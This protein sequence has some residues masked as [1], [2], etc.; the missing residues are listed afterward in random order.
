MTYITITLS[1]LIFALTSFFNDKIVSEK[2]LN[3]SKKRNERLN[4]VISSHFMNWTCILLYENV[5]N[6]IS[7]NVMVDY[8]E[9]IFLPNVEF[10][11]NI[12]VLNNRFATLSFGAKVKNCVMVYVYFQSNFDL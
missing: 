8:V 9:L 6:N 3:N 5:D 2:T 4:L 1:E 12:R 10:L 11:Y 7:R